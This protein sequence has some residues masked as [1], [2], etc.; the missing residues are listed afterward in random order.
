MGEQFPCHPIYKA[1][2]EAGR[3]VSEQWV[4]LWKSIRDLWDP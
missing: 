4:Q 3:R 2:A 1:L